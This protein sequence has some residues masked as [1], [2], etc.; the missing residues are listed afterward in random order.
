MSPNPAGLE[1]IM[2][3]GITPMNIFK[4]VGKIIAT[5]FGGRA[6]K[7]EMSRHDEVLRQQKE[8]G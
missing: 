2:N 6:Y 3:Q 7:I 5:L 8:A 1:Q 4:R